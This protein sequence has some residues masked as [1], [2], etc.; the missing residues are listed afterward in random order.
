MA[1]VGLPNDEV[2][3]ELRVPFHPRFLSGQSRAGSAAAPAR[4]AG[5]LPVALHA[6]PEESLP[7]GAHE[8]REDAMTVDGRHASSNHSYPA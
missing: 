5:E 4:P 2:S 1:A 7:G 3:Q 6:G 8:I